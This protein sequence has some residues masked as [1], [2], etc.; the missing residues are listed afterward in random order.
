MSGWAPLRLWGRRIPGSRPCLGGQEPILR[1]LQPL[2]L[3]GSRGRGCL[4]R[5]IIVCPSGVHG[6]YVP[7]HARHRLHLHALL[8]DQTLPPRS[9]PRTFAHARAPPLLRH[10]RF[11]HASI[12]QE[13]PIRACLFFVQQFARKCALGVYTHAM[14]VSLRK[15]HAAPYLSIAPMLHI[16]LSIAPY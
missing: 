12:R 9:H 3:A 1:C 2:F 16:D 8:V 4:L 7:P 11:V 6:R 13:I 15:L 14:R 10:F 5:C